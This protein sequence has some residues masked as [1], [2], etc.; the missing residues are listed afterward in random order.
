M[1]E[2]SELEQ[3]STQVS[4]HLFNHI[5]PLWCGPALDQKNG[6]WMSWLSDDLKPDRSQPKG[7]IVHAR[8]LWAFSAAHQ[9]RAEPIFSEMAQRAFDFVMTKF[10]DSEH[11]GAFWRLDDEGKVID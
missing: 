7:L 6:G 9:R 3:F 5:L 10:W 8:I 11:G 1:I 4:E 2:P